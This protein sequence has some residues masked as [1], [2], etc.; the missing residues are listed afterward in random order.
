VSCRKDERRGNWNGEGGKGIR[1]EI[2]EKENVIGRFLGVLGV[3]IGW[4]GGRLVH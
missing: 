4:R 3:L 1:S 2:K